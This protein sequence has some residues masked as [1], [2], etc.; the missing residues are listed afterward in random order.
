MPFDK[1]FNK[2]FPYFKKAE[3]IMKHINSHKYNKNTESD[4]NEA[5]KNAHSHNEEMIKYIQETKV[6]LLQSIYNNLE[7]DKG[8]KL[9]K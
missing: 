3:D 7:K 2:Y 8:D 4:I 5:K 6:L 9:G 1:Q